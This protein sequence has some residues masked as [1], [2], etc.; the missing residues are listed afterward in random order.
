MEKFLVLLKDMELLEY[1]LMT[2]SLSRN[3]AAKKEDLR[4]DG[5][6][7]KFLLQV[8]QGLKYLFKD[9]TRFILNQHGV[10]VALS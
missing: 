3:I 10:E 7:D 1:A 5:N 4:K 8:D 6:K 9:I 2:R